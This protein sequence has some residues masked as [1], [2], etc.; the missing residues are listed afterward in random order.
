MGAG[1]WPKIA[2]KNSHRRLSR[3]YRARSVRVRT[4][5]PGD[6]IIAA[7]NRDTPYEIA[8]SAIAGYIYVGRSDRI[9]GRSFIRREKSLE[10]PRHVYL[11][12]HKSLPAWQLS[13]NSRV[14]FQ[15]T[16][17]NGVL[18]AVRIYLLVSGRSVSVGYC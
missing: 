1:R 5:P 13:Y 14:Q 11:A 3:V 7:D 18:Y 4:R 12:G 8:R 10:I 9:P 6:N 2:L 15:T 17:D 16:P